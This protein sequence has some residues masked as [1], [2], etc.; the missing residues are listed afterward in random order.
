MGDYLG[1]MDTGTVLV[2]VQIRQYKFK[3]IYIHIEKKQM[4]IMY[5]IKRD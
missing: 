5:N 2:R 3:N 4:S 1:C